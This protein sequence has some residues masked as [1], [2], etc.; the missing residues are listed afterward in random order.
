MG[1]SAL[2]YF[3]VNSCTS[4]EVERIIITFENKPCPSNEIPVYMIIDGSLPNTCKRYQIMPWYRQDNPPLRR[5]SSPSQS[6]KIRET[7]KLTPGDSRVYVI[8]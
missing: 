6:D 2:Q 1:T 4:D 5:P 3:H 7:T 8:I